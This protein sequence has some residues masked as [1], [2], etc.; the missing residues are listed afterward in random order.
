[1]TESPRFHHQEKWKAGNGFVV[2]PRNY[3]KMGGS[4]SQQIKSCAAVN[5][6]N[7]LLTGSGYS[8]IIKG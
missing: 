2:F 7:R 1:M 8:L 6:V 4:P 3:P 5:R